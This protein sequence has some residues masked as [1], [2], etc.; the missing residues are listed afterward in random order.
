VQ[1][2]TRVADSTILRPIYLIVWKL[3][4]VA[5]IIPALVG[6]GCAI[7]FVAP[8][9]FYTYPDP[10]AVYTW[11][12]RMM[13]A[14]SLVLTLWL[15]LAGV[16]LLA[17]R[18]PRFQ[19]LSLSYGG[20]WFYHG[21]RSI[22]PD[23]LSSSASRSFAGALGVANT[24]ITPLELLHIPMIGTVLCLAMVLLSAKRRAAAPTTTAG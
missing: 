20:A 10:D 22:V 16:Y 17:L 15:L 24:T 5:T 4:G 8:R 11:S 3:L 7:R 14:M 9:V 23:L 19:V 12:L 21:L 2:N 13:A 1:I 18:H 6:L